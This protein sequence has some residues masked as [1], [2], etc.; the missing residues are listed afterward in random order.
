MRVAVCAVLLAALTAA[1]TVAPASGLVLETTLDPDADSSRFQLYGSKSISIE[2]ARGGALSE[3]LRDTGSRLELKVGPEDPGVQQ[4]MASLN[5]KI[6]S[7]GSRASVDDLTVLY[8]VLVDGGETY[9][10]IT[11]HVD[12]SGNIT[13]YVIDRD[14]DETTVDLGWRGLGSDES[15]VVDGGLM[16]W[17]RVPTERNPAILQESKTVDGMD[18]N[19]PLNTMRDHYPAI[20]DLVRGTVAAAELSKGAINSSSI[21]AVPMTEWNYSFG[22]QRDPVRDDTM[23]WNYGSLWA[24]GFYLTEAWERPSPAIPGEISYNMTLGS[25]G[26][27]G[28]IFVPGLATLDILEGAEVAVVTPTDLE[29]EIIPY[30]PP[31]PD[32]KAHEGNFTD[33]EAE[34]TPHDPAGAAADPESGAVAGEDLGPTTIYVAVALAVAGAGVFAVF[35]YRARNNGKD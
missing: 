20:Y 25:S 30:D 3:F 19:I 34:I 31:K 16:T 26:D 2:Y 35:R 22:P 15:I 13:G 14:R 17:W 33:L 9:T 18:I 6:R 24:H 1:W 23:S 28:L 7:D 11:F 32:A 27:K 5:E 8:R 10:S 21:L 12:L 4:L 29:V